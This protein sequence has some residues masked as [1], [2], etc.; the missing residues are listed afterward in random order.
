[1]RTAFKEWAVVVDAL[2]RGEQIIILRKGGIHEGRGGFQVG[3]KSF[4]LFPTRFHQQADS[5][6]PEAQARCEEIK[7]AMP[8]ENIL[9]LEHYAEV[10]AWREL[11]SLAAVHRLQGQ[12][13]WR[14]DVI[15]QR[16]EWGRSKGVFALATR[17][18]RLPDAVETPLIDAYGGCK[19][20]IELEREIATDGAAPVLTDAEFQ[21]KLDA[22]HEALRPRKS[23][24]RPTSRLANPSRR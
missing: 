8:A 23:E 9:R 20:W 16:Y 15:A 14:E 5:V 18:R 19:S 21:A 13:I 12:H 7:A 11:D 1:M 22:F 10:I 4:L 17:V 3:H 6:T 24:T 2:A